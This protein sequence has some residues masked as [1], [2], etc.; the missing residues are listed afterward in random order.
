MNV[1]HHDPTAARVKEIIE[2]IYS[3][4]HYMLSKTSNNF[5]QLEVNII[6]R[7]TK[8][9]YTQFLKCPIFHTG[10]DSTILYNFGQDKRR[11]IILPVLTIVYQIVDLWR[12]S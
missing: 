4:L 1:I 7:P 6:E 9:S 11:C 2:V 12:L 3:F 8:S 5:S 10:Q